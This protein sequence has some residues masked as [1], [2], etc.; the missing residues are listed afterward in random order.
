MEG[1]NNKIRWLTKQTYGFRYREYNKIENIS[2]SGYFKRQI[3]MNFCHKTS[4]RQYNTASEK[5]KAACRRVS[6]ALL[7]NDTIL[8]RDSEK[9][10]QESEAD[11]FTSE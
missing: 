8:T 11:D 7:K 1:F 5:I 3:N 2:A 10:S 6:E 4:K 9:I